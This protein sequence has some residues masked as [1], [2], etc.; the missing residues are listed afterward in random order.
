[1]NRPRLAPVD[2]AGLRGGARRGGVTSPQFLLALFAFVTAA[3]AYLVSVPTPPPPPPPLA[4]SEPTAPVTSAEVR[5]VVVDERALERPGYA[6][7]ALPDRPTPG[8]FLTAALAALRADLVASGVWP[9]A[10]P[11]PIGHVIDLDRRRLAVVDV[12]PR[13]SDVRVDVAGE[14]SAVR[15]LLATAR[16]AVPGAEV[17]VT[18]AGVETASLWGSV[19]LPRP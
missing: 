16:A 3:V 14:L 13:P 10:V 12:A 9:E 11:P 4:S 8:D 1:M 2:R 15:S 7:V 18:V 17:V 19:A 5:Y 6:D